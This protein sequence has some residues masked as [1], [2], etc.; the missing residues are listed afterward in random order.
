MNNL[1]VIPNATA[2]TEDFEFQALNEAKNYRGALLREFG[3]YLEGNV[4]EV[5]AGIGQLTE[6]LRTLPAINKLCAIEPDENF[7]ER[8]RAK[9]PNQHLVHGTVN[10]LNDREGWNTILSIN[11]LEHIE[12]DEAELKSYCDLLRESQGALCLFVP[13]R[14]EI[15]SPIDHDFGHFRRYRRTSLTL[16]LESAGF[17]ITRIRYYNFVGYFAWWLNFRILRKRS[18]EREAVR[19]F[20]RVIFPVVN[21]SERN[22][23]APPLGQSLLVVARAT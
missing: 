9:L 12:Y 10:D 3:P 5:G 2:S 6:E 13:A 21:W 17:K 4:L 18:F 14:S 19:F 11:V 1:Q 20:D 23:S 15:Y 16:K 7:C 8:I 22:I